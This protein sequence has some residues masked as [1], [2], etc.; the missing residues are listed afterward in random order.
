MVSS[1]DGLSKL[2][3]ERAQKVVENLQSWEQARDHVRRRIK[4]LK[5]SLKIFEQKI[6]S[7][8]PWPG[9]TAA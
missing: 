3:I 4:E 9:D 2:S 6:K 1:L 7:G 5:E 8:E